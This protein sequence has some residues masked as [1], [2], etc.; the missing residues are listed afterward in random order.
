M[1]FFLLDLKAKVSELE[2]RLQSHNKEMK[3]HIDKFQEMQSQLDKT[4]KDLNEKDK[5]LAKCRDELTKVSGQYDQAVT[6]V[7]IALLLWNF[8]NLILVSPVFYS[9]G[10]PIWSCGGY[11]FKKLHR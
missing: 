5:V 2:L 3:N 4:K 8:P 10:W 1:I 6:K 9:I 11:L 7:T